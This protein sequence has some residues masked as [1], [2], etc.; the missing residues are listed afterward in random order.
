MVV[1]FDTVQL[2]DCSGSPDFMDCWDAFSPMAEGIIYVAK[3][4]QKG[5][6]DDL[7]KWNRRFAHLTPNQSCV[8]LNRSIGQAKKKIKLSSKSFAKIPQVQT[9]IDQD[10]ELI[11]AEFEKFI[12]AAYL[13]ST[14]K[15]S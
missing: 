10:P 7:D 11:K 9:C 8:F 5:F 6:E 3:P 1:P 4:E 12:Q 13:A 14:Q 2:W 15:R